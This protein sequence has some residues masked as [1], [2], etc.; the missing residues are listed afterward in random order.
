MELSLEIFEQES[1]TYDVHLSA[2]LLIGFFQSSTE[3]V[4]K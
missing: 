2:V 3:V 1:A 4:A